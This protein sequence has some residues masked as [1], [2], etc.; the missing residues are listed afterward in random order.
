MLGKIIT[1]AADN[2]FSPLGPIVSLR[3]SLNS[4]SG[5]LKGN[6]VRIMNSTRCCK[7]HTNS[8]SHNV[9]G[10]TDAP[11]RREKAGMSQKTCHVRINRFKP[12]GP[13]AAIVLLPYS[14][15]VR[16]WEFLATQVFSG[17]RVTISKPYPVGYQSWYANG[18]FF[19]VFT[20]YPQG[21]NDIPSASD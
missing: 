7:S 12:T 18:N 16:G 21:N 15:I 2:G 19:W 20:L 14:A 13:W 3:S 10:A 9:I 4:A 5:E 11:R 8:H 17:K 6:H 1:F